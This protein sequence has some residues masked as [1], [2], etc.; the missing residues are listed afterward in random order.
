MTTNLQ[1]MAIVA[2]HSIYFQSTN[3]VPDSVDVPSGE[4]LSQD[5]VCSGICNSEFV[6]WV[7]NN[8]RE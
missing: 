8:F 7:L 3:Q 2:K 4:E 6:G 5:E 1:N